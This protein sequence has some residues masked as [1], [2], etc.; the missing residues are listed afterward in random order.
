MK[1]ISII[2]LGILGTMC[3]LGLSGCANKVASY[4]ISTENLMTLKGISKGNKSINLGE[5]TDS[6]KNESKVMCR[7]ATPIGTPNGETFISYIKKALEKEL[8]VADMYNKKSETKIS[9]NLDD[10]YGSTLLGNAYWEFKVTVNS[11]NGKSFKVESKYDYDSS[12]LASSACSEMQR[13]FVPAVQQLI[14]KIIGH[15][16]FKNLIQ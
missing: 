8:L 9:I 10:L 4:A 3:T 2:T 6:N 16:E 15:D 11:S 5:F 7:L 12:Y 14:G 13:S 1:K